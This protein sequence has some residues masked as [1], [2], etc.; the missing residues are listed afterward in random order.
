MR[1]SEPAEVNKSTDQHPFLNQYIHRI[2]PL[3]L[4]IQIGVN[5]E[6]DVHEAAQT[7]KWEY[8]NRV[9]R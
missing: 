9:T 6:D 1:F 7:A 3:G 2:S 5:P 8:E 4:S